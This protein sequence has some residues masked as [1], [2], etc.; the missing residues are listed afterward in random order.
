MASQRFLYLSRADVD[1]VGLDLKTTIGLLETALARTALPEAAGRRSSDAPLGSHQPEDPHPP[2][3]AQGMAYRSIVPTADWGYLR[4]RRCDYDD[5]AL[6]PWAERISTQPW[7]RAFVFFKHEE[8]KPLAW[9]AIQRFL[10]SV[11][12]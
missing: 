3:G 7:Q 12:G 1:A 9:P 11:R 4:L 2:P 10:A 5:Q 6:R 8:G